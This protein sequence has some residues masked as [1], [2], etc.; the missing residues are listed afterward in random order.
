MSLSATSEPELKLHLPM[1]LVFEL[2]L[3]WVA[4]TR[5][6][7]QILMVASPALYRWAFLLDSL[8]ATAWN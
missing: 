4:M 6:Q 8:A 5:I 1:K 3:F 7:I 2:G